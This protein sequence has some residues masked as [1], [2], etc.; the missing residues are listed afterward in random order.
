VVIGEVLRLRESL[1]WYERLPLFGRRVAVTR[2]RGQN[3]SL[4]AALDELGGDA[5]PLPTIE[6]RPAADP[7][8]QDRAIGSLESYDWLIFTSANGVRF[9]LEHLDRSGRDLRGLRAR[10]CAIGPATRAALQALHLKVDLMAEEYVA[11]GLLSAFSA[12]DL[13]GCRMLL[14]RAAMARDTVP[15]GLRAR[16]AHVD[17]V[18]AYRTVIPEEAAASAAAIFAERRPDWITFTSSST[19]RHFVQIAGAEALR[20][21]KVA[22]IGPVTSAT[23][24]SLGVEVTAE[25]EV[26][27]ADGIV[28]A[29]LAAVARTGTP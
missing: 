18:E 3:E 13:T 1:D 16:G 2:A 6:V 22:S 5:I 24:R 19:V 26:Y 17:V 10:L 20:G 11:E 14:P 21:V 15:E 12:Y 27:T 29:I 9:F 8:P 23:A 4:L 28:Q 25:A 7:A